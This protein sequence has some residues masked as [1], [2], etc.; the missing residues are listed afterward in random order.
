MVKYTGKKEMVGRAIIRIIHN[1]IIEFK[2]R[3]MYIEAK[4]KYHHCHAPQYRNCLRGN[5][6]QHGPWGKNM[7]MGKKYHFSFPH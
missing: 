1:K 6:I 3:R 5:Q 4:G 7:E 2:S